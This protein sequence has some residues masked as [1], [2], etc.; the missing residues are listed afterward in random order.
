MIGG[1]AFTYFKHF[2]V[3]SNVT[4]SNVITHLSSKTKA[5]ETL[6]RKENVTFMKNLLDTI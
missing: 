2:H 3:H 6:Q 5:E 4:A 1:D